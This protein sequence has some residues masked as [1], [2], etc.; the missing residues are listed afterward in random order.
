MLFDRVIAGGADNAV[1]FAALE[2]TAAG[3][4]VIGVAR[5]RA[6]ERRER[7]V[8]AS[9]SRIRIARSRWDAPC[10]PRWCAMRN[11]SACRA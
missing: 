5:L 4:R 10:S 6:G 8:S 11:A 7:R 3:D 2:N 1:G 9:P